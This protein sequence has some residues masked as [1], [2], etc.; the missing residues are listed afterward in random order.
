MAERTESRPLHDAYPGLAARL[1][2]VPIAALPTPV[3]ALTESRC[4]L[5]AKLDG[6]THG[7]Y[8]GNKV[9]KLEYLLAQARAHGCSSIATFGTVGSNHATATAIHARAQGLGCINFLSRQRPTP[10]LRHNLLAQAAAGARLVYLSGDREARFETVHRTLQE[11]SGRVWLVPMGGSSLTG[12]LGYV[13]AAFELASQVADDLLDEPD[14]I[15]LPLGTMGTAVG[16]ALGLRAAGLRTRVRAVRVVHESVGSRT[17]ARRLLERMA[18]LLHRM[19]PAFPEVDWPTARLEVRDDQF[20]DGYA[21]AT[22]AAR[23]ALDH[24]RDAW[25][26]AL[27]TTY[28]A[29]AAAALL[30]DR[31]AGRLDGQSVLLWSTYSARRPPAPQADAAAL[32]LPDPLRAYLDL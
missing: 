6:E 17:R 10:W 1:A 26:L 28:S 14:V 16:L 15:Y 23:A 18:A 11:N 31:D 5:H 29:K 12:A 24:A 21:L 4:R 13:N 19:E 27:E 7:V 20:G 22:P 9:R 32:G 8:G 30:A 2:H 3:R 25:G